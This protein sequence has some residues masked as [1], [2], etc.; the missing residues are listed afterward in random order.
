MLQEFQQYSKHLPSNYAYLDKYLNI[1]DL[2]IFLS[3]FS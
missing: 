3:F 2:T 1:L